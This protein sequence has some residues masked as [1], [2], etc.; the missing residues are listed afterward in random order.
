MTQLMYGLTSKELFRRAGILAEQRYP[1][2][3]SS[4]TK[5]AGIV[6]EV[7]TLAAS[8]TEA[9][10]AET[11]NTGSVHDGPVPKAGAENPPPNS[12]GMEG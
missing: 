10:R 1:D 8:G 2:G 3:C 9:R 5:L 7:I 4:A 6:R 12:P 11:E